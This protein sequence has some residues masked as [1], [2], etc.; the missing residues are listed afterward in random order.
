[1]SLRKRSSAVLAVAALVAST[2]LASSAAQAATSGSAISAGLTQVNL[3]NFNDFH[4]RIDAAAG[5]PFACLVQNERAAL[6]SDKTL[7]LSAGDNIGASLFVS[8]IQEDNPTLDYLNT[9][10]VSAAAVGNHEFDRGFSDLTRRVKDRA[11][12]PYLGA[13]VY[14]RGTKTPALPEYEVRTISGIRVGVVGVVTQET[15]SLVSP[16]GIAG[17]DFGDPIE[18]VNRVAATL[19]DGNAANGE[20]DV[21]VAEIHDGAN[22][23]KD[24]TAASTAIYDRMVKELS[25]DVDVVFNG[26]THAIYTSDAAAASGTRN[27]SQAGSYGSGL[28]R[29]KLGV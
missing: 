24:N 28:T 12:F 27:I 14:R 22:Q 10:G 8:S 2:A 18:A 9:L 1:M 15:R 17:I 7:L 25:S 4:G 29:V 13:N 5:L 6:G 19:S 21:V 3:L 23:G 26:H 16:D 11:T 20:A